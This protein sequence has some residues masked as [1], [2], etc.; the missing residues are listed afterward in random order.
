MGSAEQGT[1]LKVLAAPLRYLLLPI[2]SHGFLPSSFVYTFFHLIFLLIL[3]GSL[4]HY[5]LF[6]D[7]QNKEGEAKG[8]ASFKKEE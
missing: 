3:N 4:T 5:F 8:Y 2:I 1:F 7:G 6:S